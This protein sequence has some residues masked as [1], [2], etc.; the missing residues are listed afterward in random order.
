MYVSPLVP[1]LSCTTVEDRVT[2]ERWGTGRSVA[3]E[4][5]VLRPT[6]FI[7]VTGRGLRVR[8]TCR[9]LL[10]WKLSLLF[11][12]GRT[13]VRPLVADW[14]FLTLVRTED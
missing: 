14:F 8:H 12:D 10:L 6:D 7:N 2:K 9:P 5:E 3:R 11:F 13:P 4:I 1:T